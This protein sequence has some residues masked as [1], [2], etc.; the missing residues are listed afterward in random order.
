MTYSQILS[1]R[2]PIFTVNFSIRYLHHVIVSVS[3]DEAQVLCYSDLKYDNTV[4]YLGY[5][6]IMYHRQKACSR[7]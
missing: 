4:S 5:V 3:V 1:Q 7:P 6:K 2:L